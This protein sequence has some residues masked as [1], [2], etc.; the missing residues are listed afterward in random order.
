MAHTIVFQG[1][2]G[3]LLE[4]S[5]DLAATI[6]SGYLVAVAP[7]QSAYLIDGIVE[8][9]GD[10]SLY[11][12]KGSFSTLPVGHYIV[13]PQLIDDEGLIY[14]LDEAEIDVHYVPGATSYSVTVP[15]VFSRLDDLEDAVAN[16][17]VG[18]G[19]TDH[20][21]L[22]GLADDDHTQYHNDARGDARYWALTTDLATQTELNNEAST[23]ASADTTNATNLTT[24]AA[25]TTSAHGG[26]VASNDSRLTDART[27]TA[28]VHPESDVTSLVTDLAGK[29]STV[30]T[31]AE[32]DVT[33]LVT[34]LAAKLVKASNLS[35]LVN[36]STARTNLGL[37]TAAVAASTDFVSATTTRTANTVFA[38]PTTGS[39]AAPTFRALIAT[40]IPDLAE[41]QITNLVSDLAAKAA[42]V[43]THV[44]SDITSL[45]TDLGLKAPLASPTFTGT[46]AA[47][48][49]AGGTN[50]TQL[51]TTAFVTTAVANIIDAA[52]GTLDT[53]NELAAALGDD[54]N[55]A[56]TITTLIGTKI[57]QAQADTLYSPIGHNHD[58]RYYT[59]SEIDTF[60]SSYQPLDSDLTAIAGLTA[61]TDNFIV[62]VA[63]AW[64]SR[65]PAQV[66]TT[67][68]LVVGTNVQAYDADLTV[69]ADLVD[70][71]AD[72][73]LFWDDSAGSYAY[74]TVGSGLSITGTTIDAIAGGSGTVTSVALTTPSFLS[75]A[76][77]PINTSGTFDVTLATQVQ[78]RVFAGPSSG[79]DAA[80]TF[81]ALVA[82][83]IPSLSSVYQ[84]LDSD[85]TAIAGLTATTD[86][87]IVSVS[88][89]WASRTP[90][91][92]R[93]TLGLVIGTDVQAYD[94]DL[95]VIA[96]LVDPNIDRILFWDDSAG[97]YAYL[98]AGTGLSIS[99]TTITAAG[100]WGSI[101]GT[102]S[103][104][105]DLQAAL[106]LKSPLA[107]PTF[108]GTPAAPTATGGTN[109]TQIATT[110]FVTSAVSTH[111]S[112]TTSVHGIADTSKVALNTTQS[113][114]D[115]ANIS[116]DVSLGGYATVTLGGN[117]TLDNPTNMV[118]GASYA[119]KLTQDGSGG[120]TLAYGSAYKWS[121]G[122]PVL[123]TAIGAVDIITFVSD[124]TNMYGS[125]LKGFA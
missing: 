24:H 32:S 102:L 61:T 43:H 9:V 36:A 117:R 6:V 121:G 100:I 11:I 65:T 123:S 111:E 10:D 27:P 95:A 72:R 68:N 106:D 98:E 81:R 31:H 88:S 80:P 5:F 7:D 90:A 101:T 2:T 34:D 73:I 30:H 99:G 82:A 29:A 40:D 62:S 77:S 105:T 76:G 52:P 33:S 25:L 54:P 124:G 59:E 110:A 42:S 108:T 71:N 74:L 58:S 118:A 57:T 15:S 125:I 83:D 47:P 120:R 45:V 87:F 122:A 67:L 28:H 85:L 23:R 109:T 103:S 86:N 115:G 39:P 46:P 66:R 89:A 41:S 97:S 78:N 22:T 63:N 70:P 93:T 21:L 56:T 79:A 35:D 64:A 1:E 92:V 38:G 69:I 91:Q 8:F 48:T 44:E 94:A 116:W 18:G 114:S 96:G 16:I 13:L 75:V 19:V 112:D 14:F 119:I 50:T 26:I 113:L 37:G 20:G 55:F 51:A 4:F 60:L 84:P 107:S 17:T 12:S 104:Q 3:G 53:L 49:A